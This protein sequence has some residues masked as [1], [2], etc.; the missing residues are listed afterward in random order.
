MNPK[1]SIVR[2]VERLAEAYGVWTPEE[3]T[4]CANEECENHRRGRPKSGNG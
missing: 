3:S 4:G 1:A 2:E